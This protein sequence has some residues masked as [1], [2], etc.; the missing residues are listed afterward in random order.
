MDWRDCYDDEFFGEDV[1]SLGFR[2]MSDRYGILSR[3]G[4]E[5]V[6]LEGRPVSRTKRSHPYSYDGHVVTRTRAN[7]KEMECV[8]TDRLAGWD[9]GK[10]RRLCREHLE[11]YRWDNAPGRSVQAFLQDWEEDPG[12]ELVAVMEWCNPSSSYA[13][14]S[15][16]F[17]FSK[18]KQAQLLEKARKDSQA[19][20]CWKCDGKFE[21]GDDVVLLEKDYPRHYHRVCAP[22]EE[23]G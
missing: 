15:L 19:R 14:W 23:Q 4:G 21:E 13:T 10:F 20:G 7:A 22:P 8:Y 5:P 9:S 18:K 12:L 3:L 6:D 17:V 2:R 1:R 11:G 16:H